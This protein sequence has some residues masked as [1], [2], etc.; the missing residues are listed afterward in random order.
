MAWTMVGKPTTQVAD[1]SLVERFKNMNRFGGDRKLDPKRCARLRSLFNE[2]QF[3]TCAWAVV[4]CLE[5]GNEYRVNGQHTSHVLA[6]FNGSLPAVFVT[7][8]RYEA[9]TLTDVADLFATFD[10]RWSN[11]TTSDTNRAFASSVSALADLNNRVIDLAA[12]GM[13][14][15]MG[16]GFR[17]QMTQEQRGREVAKHTAFVLWLNGLDIVTSKT[18]RYLAKAA[19]C[20][21]MFATYSKD[22][23]QATEFWTAVRNASEPN[24]EHPTRLLER[25][26]LIAKSRSGDREIYAKCLHAWN[27]WRRGAGSLKMLKWYPEADR[28]QA[29]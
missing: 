5:D 13:V 2:G 27:A 6:E 3:R 1:H 17:K 12:S 8:E 18:K 11:R 24:A 10:N 19:I 20:A 25:Y 21:A 29:I 22:S 4:K 9:D 15:F 28:V 7:V 26:L 14:I 16:D 23:E